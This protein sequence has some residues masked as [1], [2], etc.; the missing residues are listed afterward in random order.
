MEDFAPH[1]K[2]YLCSWARDLQYHFPFLAEETIEYPYQMFYF[3]WKLSYLW[4]VN[5]A[6]YSIAFE[7][8]MDRYD[9][10][11]KD[12]LSFVGIDTYDIELLRTLKA[13]PDMGKWRTYA[14][15]AWFQQHES[16]CETVLE[17]FFVSLAHR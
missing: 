7:D 9:S 3:L 5:F 16:R 10:V 2:F 15:E 14:D 17:D 12:M 4:G 11:L 6:H 13:P 8:L 1:D